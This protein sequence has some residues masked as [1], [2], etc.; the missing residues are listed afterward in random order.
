MREKEREKEGRKGSKIKAFNERF[1]YH[2][3]ND[4]LSMLPEF[5]NLDGR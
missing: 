2:A 4:T 5:L 3:K 1:N